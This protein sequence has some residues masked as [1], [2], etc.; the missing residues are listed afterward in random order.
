[1]KRFKLSEKY[2]DEYCQMTRS[3]LSNW[4]FEAE[5]EEDLFGCFGPSGIQGLIY[6]PGHLEFVEDC[7]PK[8]DPANWNKYPDV[9]PPQGVVMLVRFSD[10]L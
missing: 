7:K 8:Y 6:K 5:K 4:R 10:G 9:A 3:I 2:L 1:M